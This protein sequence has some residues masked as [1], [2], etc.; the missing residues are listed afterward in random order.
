LRHLDQLLKPAY[1]IGS[2]V[3]RPSAYGTCVLQRVKSHLGLPGALLVKVRVNGP[4]A[5]FDGAGDAEV[6]T[7]SLLPNQARE[8]DTKRI[9]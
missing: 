7:V 5:R 3:F 1:T 8:A 9:V 2:D 4:P 6:K